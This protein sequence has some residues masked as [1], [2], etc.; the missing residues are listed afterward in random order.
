LPSVGKASAKIQP[1]HKTAK[2]FFKKN[3]GNPRKKLCPSHQKVEKNSRPP[4]AGHQDDA[5]QAPR[6]TQKSNKSAHPHTATQYHP[7]P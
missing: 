3:S 6:D 5:S 7:R 1:F 2:Y 4:L